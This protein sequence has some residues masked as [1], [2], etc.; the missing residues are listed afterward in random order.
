MSQVTIEPTT[1]LAKAVAE[2]NLSPESAARLQAVFAPFYDEA[3]KLIQKGQTIHVTDPS[4][5]DDIKEACDTR[6]ALKKVRTG[7]DHARKDEGEGA[8]KFKRGVDAIGG[9]VIAWCEAEETR[10]MAMEQIAARI[11][12]ERKAKLA[13]DRRAQL[14]P[15]LGVN[16]AYYDLANMPEPAFKDLLATELKKKADAEIAARQAEADRLAK[17]MAEEEARQEAEA[18]R[19]RVAEENAK[20][21]KKAEAAEKA[22]QAE[23]AKLRA[24][25]AKKDEEAKALAAVAEKKRMDELNRLLAEQ[26]KAN[27]AAKAERDAIEA[28]AIAEHRA[29]EKEREAAAAK[30]REQAAALARAQAKA[31]ALRAAEVAKAKAEADRLARAA[32][33][34]D[35]EKLLAV[36]QAVR[37]IRVPEMTTTESQHAA[38]LIFAILVDASNRIA[39]LAANL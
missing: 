20:L 38:S 14:E 3:D 23:L 35:R 36:A 27:A 6:K 16:I 11:Q 15:L 26:A 12:A 32:R 13:A 25:Q 37:D 8:L 7:A 24:E 29:A 1:A 18:E 2:S 9:K 19:A 34:P 10:L 17:E 30:A 21:K 5:V 33:A 4:Q 39:A 28:K 22:R 31:D